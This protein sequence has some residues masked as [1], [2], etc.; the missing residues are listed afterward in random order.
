MSLN[1]ALTGIDASNTMLTVVSDNIANA[2][3]TGFK[4]SRAEFGDL[5][6]SMSQNA[7][8]LGV[9]LQRTTQTFK[10]GSIATTDNAFDMAI[11]GDGFFQVKNGTS[12][13]YTRAGSFRG[14][15][16]SALAR[17]GHGFARGRQ[18]PGGITI[19]GTHS[20]VRIRHEAGA[21]GHR[22]EQ[23]RRGHRPVG[24]SF[25]SFGRP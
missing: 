21:T 25:A 8:G 22:R 23:I 5:V 2:N 19:G 9:R 14:D 18:A 6:D 10:Q 15:G 3:T 13:L 12:T 4:R 20:M 1:I 16:V 24:T 11:T 7:A 17:F